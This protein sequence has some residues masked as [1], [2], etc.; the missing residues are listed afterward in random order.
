MLSA[1]SVR[2]PRSAMLSLVIQQD[3]L[4]DWLQLRTW[5]TLSI[6]HTV[7]TSDQRW[8]RAL[9]LHYNLTGR[10]ERYRGHCS[11]CALVSEPQLPP[12]E[13]NVLAGPK[14]LPDR[15]WASL[16]FN[17]SISPSHLDIPP[18][19]TPHTHRRCGF[20]GL[21]VRRAK[22]RETR[23]LVQGHR[24]GRPGW[25]WALRTQALLW[26]SNP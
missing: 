13:N 17:Q 5:G 25:S 23:Q 3:H 16:S 22:L 6:N 9:L 14:K 10:Q 19:P 11:S 18:T 15:S 4:G 1:S 8:P 21:Q 7:C 24:V 20:C 12:S 2:M 26:G